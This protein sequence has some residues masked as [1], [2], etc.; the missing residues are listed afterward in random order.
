MRFSLVSKIFVLGVCEK[1]KVSECEYA[2]G[3]KGWGGGAGEYKEEKEKGRVY[4][5]TIEEHPSKGAKA[6]V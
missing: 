6:T 5:I 1:E 3:G 2:Y 4:S